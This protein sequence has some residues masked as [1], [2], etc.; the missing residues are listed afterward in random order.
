MIIKT[1]AKA[2]V[3]CSA[4]T[5]AGWITL[6]LVDVACS[7]L[8]VTADMGSPSARNSLS[9]IRR[10][11]ALR[12]YQDTM[13]PIPATYRP[14]RKSEPGCPGSPSTR[15]CWDQSGAHGSSGRRHQH[16]VDHMDHAVRLI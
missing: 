8:T 6:L 11:P 4:R 3:Q 15:P 1:I 13:K 10:E 16:G 2:L 12:Y 7:S 9:I 14:S 5:Q